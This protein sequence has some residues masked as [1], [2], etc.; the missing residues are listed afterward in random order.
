MNRA[1]LVYILGPSGAGKDTVIAHARA[2]I[3]G[4]LPVA[5]AHRYI[6]RPAGAGGEYHVALTEAEF[7]RRAAGGLF[8]MSWQGNGLSYGI[9]VEVDAWRAAGLTVVVNGSR[10]YLAQAAARY[11]DL[12]PVLVTVR[13]EE[14]RRRLR[15]RGRETAAEIEARLVRAAAFTID[16]PRLVRLDNSG[17]VAEAGD[18]LVSLLRRVA[19]S[20]A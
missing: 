15:A 6:T 17:P 1:P 10:G 20:P 19:N 7:A 12:L 11:P 2:V 4:A 5:F 8:A 18:R 3:D 16:H 14:L 9:G 13:S